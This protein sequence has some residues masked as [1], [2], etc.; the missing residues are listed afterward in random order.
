MSTTT[1]RRTRAANLQA[2]APAT[3]APTDPN[4]LPDWV[5]ETPEP[6][7]TYQLAMWQ[8]AIDIQGIDL[9]REEFIALKQ[10]LAELRGY[11]VPKEGSEQAA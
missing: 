4:A 6:W 5:T 8:D 7:T 1:K 9:S 2:V 10:R 3:S 11:S